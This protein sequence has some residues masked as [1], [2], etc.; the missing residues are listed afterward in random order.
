MTKEDRAETKIEEKTP[1]STP[2]LE[3]LLPT[4]NVGMVPQKQEEGGELS[5]LISDDALLG[6]YAEIMGNLRD[7]RKELDEYISTFANM[8]LNDGDATTSS[9]EALVNLVKIKSDIPDKMAKV[10][11]LMTRIKL[12]ERDTF[13]RYLAAHQNNTIN[14]GEGGSKRALL[15]AIEQ[16]KKGK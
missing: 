8:V 5:R 16:A 1:L 7:D 15:E 3:K 13:P 2:E 10:A 12:K 11:D 6:V 9:K 4:M 14:I